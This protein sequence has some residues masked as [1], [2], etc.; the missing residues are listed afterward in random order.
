M[1]PARVRVYVASSLDGF[2]AGP[3]DDLSWLPTP[4]GAHDEAANERGTDP[5]ALEYEDF[6]A[7]VGAL[8]IGRGT[9]DVVR[10]FGGSWPYGDRAVLVATH[11]ALD[12]DP[13][14]TVR[15][16]QGSI[17]ALIEHG[18]AERDKP[19][20]ARQGFTGGSPPSEGERGTDQAEPDA[21]GPGP[22]DVA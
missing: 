7:T 1:S 22:E 6:I 17:A 12:D 15:P 21:G 4:G 9:Y 16:V 5:D 14:A 13:P 19:P 2:I 8:L 20:G 10:G 3:G 18:R 11:R